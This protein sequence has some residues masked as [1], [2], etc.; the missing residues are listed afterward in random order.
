M[1]TMRKDLSIIILNYRTRGLLKQCIR[2]VE[3]HNIGVPYE[4]LV[5]DNAS[6]DGTAEMMRKEFPSCS[7]IETEINL[8]FGG[9]MN[10]G[11][12]ASSGR[13][14]LLLNTDIA[15]FDH[16][17]NDMYAYME[18]HPHVGLVGPKLI[19][20]NGSIQLSC[21]RFPSFWAALWRRSPLGRLPAIKKRLREYL[22][23]DFNHATTQPVEWV[24]GACMM[25]RKSALEQVGPFDEHFFLYVEDTDICRRFWEYGW[26]VHYLASVEMVH[27]HERRSAE[28]PGL[29]GVFSYATRVHI[30]S[31]IWYFMKY[32]KRKK[33]VI[34]ST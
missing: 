18:S 10:R 34:P 24:L 25:I 17:I 16:A 14:V 5:V 1:I 27:Y 2:G 13:Y 29:A 19:N 22:M 4:I 7:F 20:P 23:L 12:R 15:V 9:G 26:Q 8:G 21:Y 31:W 30:R 28:N 32:A 3:Q 33:P 6:H 11:I